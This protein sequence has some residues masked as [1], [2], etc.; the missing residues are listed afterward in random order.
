M[1]LM[2]GFEGE[3]K[4]KYNESLYLLFQ[5]I[6]CYLPLGAV[7]NKKV[8]VMHG[9]LFSND[10]VTLEDIN[11]VDRFREPPDEGI[12]SEML[13]SDPQPYPGRGPSKRGVGSMFGPDVTNTFLKKNN[14]ELLV[15][16]HEMKDNGYHVEHDGKC[17]T[18]FSAPNYCDQMGNKGAFI[19]FKSDMV[20]HFTTFGAVPHP[21]VKPMQYASNMLQ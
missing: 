12:M 1:N 2:Y 7:L 6:F 5:E 16:S 19:K 4:S 14:L 18:I 9:G 21:S 20:P 8:I 3:V 13:W 11:K 10:N 15:R 17:I